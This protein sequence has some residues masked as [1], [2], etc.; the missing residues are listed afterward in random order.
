MSPELAGIIGIILLLVLFALRMSV[1][2]SMLA[3]GFLGYAYLTNTSVS[4]PHR[5]NR[6]QSLPGG[7]QYSF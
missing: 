7:D 1:G 5:G 4:H 6:F 2:L 3:V